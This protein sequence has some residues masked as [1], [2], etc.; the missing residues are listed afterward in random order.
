MRACALLVVMTLL[1]GAVPA[2]GAS[3][4]AKLHRA[5]GELGDLVSQIAEQAAAIDDL[6]GRVAAADHRIDVAERALGLVLASRIAVRDELEAAQA[7]YADAESRLHDT[8]V[9]AFMNSP[10]G[11]AEADVLGAVL[12][13]SSMGDLQDRLALGDAIV[14]DRERAVSGLATAKARLDV[15]ARELDG[16]LAAQQA[17]VQELRVAQEEQ[18][19]ALASEQAALAQLSETRDRIVSLIARLK[20]RLHAEDVAAVARAFQG[21]DHVSYGQWADM[22]LHI[23]DAPTCRENQVVVVAWQVQEFTQ[24]AWN[25][26]ATTHRMPGSTDFNGVGVQN[27]VSLEQGLEATKETIQ[28]GWD[29]Y[30]YGAIVGSLRRCDDALT[31]ASRI[32]ASSWC[33]GCLDGNYVVGVVPKVEAD[34]ETYASL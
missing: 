12:Q 32:A 28:N 17:T 5:Q 16:A 19:N 3:T 10:G 14:A 9:D 13:A 15:R 2:S 1:V 24:A 31:S 21:A 25:P 30:G 18:A 7:A 26:L 6:R 23:F 8:V 33:P 22:L 34:F 11:L 29:I 27:F 20:Q 4:D